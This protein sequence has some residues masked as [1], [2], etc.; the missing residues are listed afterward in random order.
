VGERRL[1]EHHR[2]EKEIARQD[3]PTLRSDGSEREAVDGREDLVAGADG[4]RVEIAQT[5]QDR[6]RTTCGSGSTAAVILG[7]YKVV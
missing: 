2:R 6:P 1:P 4:L 5:R 7:V 3:V